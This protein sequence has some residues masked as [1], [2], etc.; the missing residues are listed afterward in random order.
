ML[1]RDEVLLL[2]LILDRVTAA[3]QGRMACD[4]TGR[5]GA[6]GTLRQVLFNIGVHMLSY[7]CPMAWRVW[8]S[9]QIVKTHLYVE[10]GW[11]VD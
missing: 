6:T 10:S 4:L 11:L 3:C 7:D 9:R 2:P 5:D 1:W 8:H